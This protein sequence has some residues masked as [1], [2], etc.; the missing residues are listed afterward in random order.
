[1]S[2]IIIDKIYEYDPV[3][4]YEIQ[5][6][7]KSEMFE[8]CVFTAQCVRC[9]IFIVH[10]NELAHRLFIRF[11]FR[12]F[13]LCA[14]DDDALVKRWSSLVFCLWANR[15]VKSKYFKIE[16]FINWNFEYL[17]LVVVLLIFFPLSP[18]T[19]S[20]SLTV[21]D[22]ILKPKCNLDGMMGRLL[23]N[24]IHFGPGNK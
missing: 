15:R 16:E 14:Y 5:M 12:P 8:C 4:S 2:C 11:V 23:I 13:Y 9:F 19:A 20:A 6:A 24:K 21:G 18:L 1:M 3:S 7:A 17:G 22:F 10:C